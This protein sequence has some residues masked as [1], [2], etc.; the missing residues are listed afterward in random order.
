[1]TGHENDS[2][3]MYN[4]RTHSKVAEKEGFHMGGTDEPR[5]LYVGNLDPSVTEEF[6]GTLFGQIGTVTKTK[7]I[8]DVR[9]ILSCIVCASTN[10]IS[11]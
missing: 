5:T 8:F 6:I 10:E 2:A 3:G 9:F 11:D 7:V 4:P 1:M